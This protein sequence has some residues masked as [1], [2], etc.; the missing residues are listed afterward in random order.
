[1]PVVS[2]TSL[3]SS[4]LLA[5]ALLAACATPSPQGVGDAA[6]PAT[7]AVRQYPVSDFFRNVE[8]GNY[9]LS[10]DGKTL[11]FMQPALGDDGKTKRMNIFVQALDGT[12][13]TGEPRQITFESARDVD[14]YGWKGSRTIL[15]SKDF[16]GDEN[17]HLVAVDVASGKTAD[18]TPFK[19]IQAEIVDDL[20][21]DA[22]HVLIAHNK[23]DKRVKDVYRVDVRSGASTMVARNPGG[24]TGW[25]T[26]HK[27]R[28]RV[29]VQSDGVNS[30]VLYRA[31]EKVPFKPIIATDF[32]TQVTPALFDFDDKML[33]ALSNRGRDLLALVIID[34]VAP[35]KERVLHEHDQVDVAGVQH[36]RKRKVLTSA[37]FVVD[38]RERY[39]FDETARDIY[40]D[41]EAKLPDYEVTLQSNDKAENL[42][43]VAA[44]SDRTRGAR[45]LYDAETGSLAKLGDVSPW[46]VEADMA[47]MRPVSYVARDGMTVPAYLTL[48]VGGATKNLACVV[49]PH[50]G[51]W[52]RDNWRFNPEV[53]FLANR[54]YCV[55]QMNFRGSTGY[56]RK[57]WEAGFRQWGLAMQDDITDGVNWLVKEGIADPKRVAIYGAS[58]GG[59]AT[60]A[61]LTQTP[62]LYAAAVDYVGVSNLFTFMGTIPP[63]WEPFRK[64][65]YEMVGNPDD[66]KEKERL[67][68][69]SPALNVDKIRTP[70]FVA[71]GARDPR[72]NK[73]ESDQIVEALKKRG[74]DVEYMVK[75]NEGH[76]FQNEEN[77][78]DF[79]QAM[80]GFL[81]RHLHPMK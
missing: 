31:N 11:A 39:F 6:S 13:T 32:R 72:V 22:H 33:Y 81:A 35:D 57:F 45:Y 46:L 78:L 44:S 21:N 48:P 42:F 4:L 80:E 74:I 2:R 50:G 30:K 52:A 69:T 77:R 23:R 27:G 12:Q 65:M 70:L 10:D 59:Y 43:I 49:N 62:D 9:Q 53:Q 14:G 17:Y 26:D 28:V 76:G 73:A 75:D 24:V 64:Q 66:A 25:M 55:L 61:G 79:Y 3:L 51:P 19:D 15:F 37:D 71:Q 7:E 20:D 18:L 5:S 40:A 16:G 8:R 38:R 56:G 67:T 34:P 54:G 36:S 68:A 63:Y 41:L 47:P 58:Y 29:A 1:M 60:L